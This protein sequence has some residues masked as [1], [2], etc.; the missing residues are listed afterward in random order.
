MTQRWKAILCDMTLS[1]QCWWR[2]KSSVMLHWAHI[3]SEKTWLFQIN[4]DLQYSNTIPLYTMIKMILKTDNHQKNPQQ[5]KIQ[6]VLI[7]ST[8]TRSFFLYDE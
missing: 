1:Q 7:S 5:Y 4:C 3:T 2:L 6:P 8:S